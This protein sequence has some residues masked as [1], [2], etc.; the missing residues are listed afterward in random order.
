M[1]FDIWEGDRE[2]FYK[3]YFGRHDFID[4]L[5]NRLRSDER[6]RKRV[7]GALWDL[8]EK[9]ALVD[10]YTFGV[11]PSESIDPRLSSGVQAYRGL[12]YKA[13]REVMGIF[14]RKGSNEVF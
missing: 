11:A 3:M 5:A 13:F 6:L 10:S 2:D 9:V 14:N 4:S 12:L 8:T 1:A 7:A